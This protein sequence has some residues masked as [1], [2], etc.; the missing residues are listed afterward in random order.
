LHIL[1]IRSVPAAVVAESMSV[2]R[3]QGIVPAMR[4]CE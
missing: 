1:E 3:Y 2:N 4:A